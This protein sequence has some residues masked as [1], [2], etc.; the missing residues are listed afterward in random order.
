MAQ[1]PQLSPLFF[2]ITVIHEV[3]VGVGSGPIPGGEAFGEVIY[4][5]MDGD[6]D[7]SVGQSGGGGR[8]GIVYY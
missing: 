7:G 6:D 2:L 3:E 8:G 5:T 1:C 4:C